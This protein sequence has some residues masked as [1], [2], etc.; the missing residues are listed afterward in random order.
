MSLL[1]TT[2][3]WHVRA[4][5][6]ALLVWQ[7]SCSP[8]SAS[9]PGAATPAQPPPSETEGIGAPGS[10]ARGGPAPWAGITRLAGPP[11]PNEC[12]FIGERPWLFWQGESERAQLVRIARLP[13]RVDPLPF[14]P[15]AMLNVSAD[16]GTTR[17]VTKVKDGWL[18]AMQRGEFGGGVFW[19]QADTLEV[20]QLDAH[21]GEHVGWIGALESGVVGVAGLCHGE[22]CTHRTSV[23]EILPW[24]DGGWRLQP[25]ALFNGCPGAVGFG[26]GND[27]VLIGAS[28]GG[29][30]RVDRRGARQVADWPRYLYPIQVSSA[31]P[32]EVTDELYYVSFGRVAA[33]F[34][35]AGAEWFAP[36]DCI[37]VESGTRNR[38]RC[39]PAP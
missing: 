29:L 31:A 7:A 16:S 13:T 2:R 6:L 9:S 26:V 33:R 10:D 11:A 38:C 3:S 24:P 22:M 15:P 30:Q 23:Y 37:G 14:A 1:K 39:V 8:S 28:C 25:L 21:L 5:L 4:S 19:V 35:P 36:N 20:K 12:H 32:S 17:M 27:S 18:V 34:G